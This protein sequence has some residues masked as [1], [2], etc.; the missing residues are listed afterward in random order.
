M[1]F[2]DVVPCRER[3]LALQPAVIVEGEQEWEDHRTPRGRLDYV[4]ERAHIMAVIDATT[5][6]HRGRRRSG[7]VRAE[8]AAERRTRAWVRGMLRMNPRKRDRAPG[9]CVP[10][11]PGA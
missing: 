8:D 9:F 6:H 11:D 3:R 10:L 7:K 2:E 4:S 5:K 1:R